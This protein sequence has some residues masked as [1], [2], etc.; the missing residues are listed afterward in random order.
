MSNDNIDVALGNG[1]GTFQ[2]GNSYPTGLTLD[3]IVGSSLTFHWFSNFSNSSQHV[4]NYSSYYTVDSDSCGSTGGGQPNPWVINS[5]NG[6]NGNVAAQV[7]PCQAGGHYTL[8]LVTTDNLGNQYTAVTT[9]YVPANGTPSPSLTVN[10]GTSISASVGGSL[11]F[12]WDDPSG[13][14]T[15][16]TST[17]FVDS[18]YALGSAYGDDCGDSPY[19]VEYP[20]AANSLSGGAGAQVA[21]CQAYEPDPAPPATDSGHVYSMN[22]QVSNGNAGLQSTSTVTVYVNPAVPVTAQL[23][24][25]DQ[26]TKAS[27]NQN[28]CQITASPGD[29]LEFT[30]G[31]ATGD[32]LGFFAA[33][34][35][36]TVDSTDACGFAGYPVQNSWVAYS[37]S[38]PAQ[39]YIGTIAACQAGHT[40]TI[41]Y[42]VYGP[43]G[44]AASS[45]VQVQVNRTTL[46]PWHA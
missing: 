1:D 7:A 34:S 9:V 31:P 14:G 15:S 23:G 45:A 25:T 6:P 28:N 43:N 33:T 5:A 3:A 44:S 38:S 16:A 46:T 42:R 8:Y 39:G 24:V 21:N 35:Y 32:S 17:Y 41:T 12:A 2:S 36:F 40:Y 19:P 37:F 4:S 26:T 27:C 30:W 29:T 18:A 11:N 20:W 22:Y 10:S 13:L